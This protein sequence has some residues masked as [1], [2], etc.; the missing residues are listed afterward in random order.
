LTG[1]AAAL[2]TLKTQLS[3]AADVSAAEAAMAHFT[4]AQGFPAYAYVALRLAGRDLSK[5]FRSSRYPQEWIIRYRECNFQAVDPTLPTSVRALLPFLWSDLA[6]S[7]NVPDLQ[8][9][10]FREAQEFGLTHGITVPI[11]G[12]GDEAGLL[13]LAADVGRGEFDARLHEGLH[14]LT[15]AA[16]LYHA[17]VRNLVADATPLHLSPRELEILTWAA[18]G[19]TSWETARIVGISENTVNFHLKKVLLRLGTSNKREAVVK[20]IMRGLIEP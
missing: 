15:F 10:V 12:A 8:R 9:Q 6:E 20:G 19:K 16:T 4:Q 2:H 18:R 14:T 3:A 5:P 7:S 17:T 11:H 1:D 13:S